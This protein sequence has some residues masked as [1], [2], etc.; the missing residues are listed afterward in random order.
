MNNSFLKSKWSIFIVTSMANLGVSF[1]INSLNLALPLIREEFGVSQSD[2]SWLALVYSLLP[3]CMLLLFGR[4]ADICGYRRQYLF[5]FGF[6]TAVSMLAPVLSF[7]LPTLIVFRALQGIG[8]SILI[9]ITQATIFKTFPENERGKA[10]GINSVFVSVGFAA[11]PTIGG[12]LLRFFTWHSIFYFCAIFSVLG[13]IGTF[14]AMEDDT[15]EKE[16]RPKIDVLGG[17]FFMI[18]IGALSI[19]INFVDDWGLSWKIGTLFAISAAGLI[20]FLLREKQAE[21]PLLS[22][23]IFKNRTFTLANCTCL[24]SYLT[25]Q[26]T[27]YLYP[28]FLADVMMMS[29]YHS[30]LVMLTAPVMMMIFSPLGGDISDKKGTKLPAVAGLALIILSCLGTAFFHQGQNLFYVIAVLALMGAGNGLS[31]SAINNAILGSVDT[32]MSG[33]ASGTLATM[34]NIGNTLGIAIGSVMLT[35]REVHYSSAG[36]SQVSVYLKSQRDIFLF[37]A[38]AAGVAIC[39]ILLIH[40]R[41]KKQKVTLAASRC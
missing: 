15:T 30:G 9:S 36:L 35:M 24:L 20:L 40:D 33:A 12:V 21:H 32:S 18:F 31:V 6:F 41:K 5:G 4:L 22:L 34:R 23:S 28:F 25:Q 2:V 27:T 8:Y 1:A 26:L 14:L 7:N 3:S 13:L 11:G 39:F 19:G 16:A 37:G 10:L 29:A 38:A 17:F